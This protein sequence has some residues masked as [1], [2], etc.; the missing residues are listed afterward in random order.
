MAKNK[1][2]ENTTG[3]ALDESQYTEDEN[4]GFPPYWNPSEG[5]KFAATVITLDDGDPDFKRW[6]FQAA[7]DLECHTGPKGEDG[8]EPEKVLVKKGEFFS[9]SDYVQFRLHQYVGLEVM[10]YVKG[11]KVK[12]AGGKTMWSM[13]MRVSTAVKELLNKRRMERSMGTGV[14]MASM[15]GATATA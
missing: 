4:L 1:G 5:G 7:H 12:I 8:S 9:T 14:P 11:G 3:A 2:S 6:V 13:G 10:I 15:G